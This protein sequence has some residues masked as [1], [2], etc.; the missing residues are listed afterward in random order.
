MICLSWETFLSFQK[1][2]S[3]V[4]LS[5]TSLSSVSGEK[6]SLLD[7][8]NVTGDLSSLY[9]L[10]VNVWS[11]LSLWTYFSSSESL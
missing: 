7:V 4:T 5:E 10:I 8:S 1:A 11:S 2:S 3:E 6:E 9:Y